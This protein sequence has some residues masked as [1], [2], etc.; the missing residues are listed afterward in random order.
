MFI[1]CLLRHDATMRAG[2]DELVDAVHGRF[3]AL[4]FGG[5]DHVPAGGPQFLEAVR[6]HLEHIV[7]VDADKLPRPD[8]A[9]DISSLL[10]ALSS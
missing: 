5:V 2:T 8:Q 1:P 4:V 9:G 3:P 6:R 7:H 10:E